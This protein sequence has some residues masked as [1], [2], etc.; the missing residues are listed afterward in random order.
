LFIDRTVAVIGDGDLGVRSALELAQNARQVYYITSSLSSLDNS[1]GKK[2]TASPNVTVLAGY[3]VSQIKGDETYARSVIARKDGEEQELKV[4]VTFVEM[5]LE[6]NSDCVANLVELNG[7]KQIKID[8]HNSTS[9]PGIFAAGDVTDTFAE[10]VLIC[11]GEGA[12]AALS[13]Y[14]YL[15]AR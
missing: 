15:L 4:D 10:Q 14:E 2:L 1:M 6:P 11:I 9:L 13:A 7:N 8:S 12:K 5:G 3:Q